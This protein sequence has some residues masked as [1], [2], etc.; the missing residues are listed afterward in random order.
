MEET[1]FLVLLYLAGC[2]V[3]GLFVFVHWGCLCI[4]WTAPLRH[5]LNRLN[6]TMNWLNW[7]IEPFS[8][9]N[10]PIIRLF[11]YMLWQFV[12]IISSWVGVAAH[13]VASSNRLWDFYARYPRGKRARTLLFNKKL[14]R[15]STVQHLLQ[16]YDVFDG[17]REQMKNNVYHELE[18]LDAHCKTS[19]EWFGEPEILPEIEPLSEEESEKASA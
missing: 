5:N 11:Q 15:N 13:I 4:L 19:F 7:N 6:L 12:C 17:R 18:Y 10:V 3:S 2:L 8:R 1:P 9:Q 16:L 14:S